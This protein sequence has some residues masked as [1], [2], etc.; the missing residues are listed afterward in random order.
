LRNPWV[1]PVQEVAAVTQQ[2]L[3]KQGAQALQYGATEG[4]RPLRK[5]LA[6]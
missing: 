5:W 4:Y 1:F 6:R 3:R 2:I